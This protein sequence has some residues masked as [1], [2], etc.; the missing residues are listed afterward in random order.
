MIASLE[1][2]LKHEVQKAFADSMQT[3]WQTMIG[4][5]GIGFLS[6]F[7]M[8][9]IAMVGVVDEKYALQSSVQDRVQPITSDAEKG[10]VAGAST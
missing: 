5:A 7:L 4:I 9:E 6:S 1:E 10:A 3:I 8:K 2:P